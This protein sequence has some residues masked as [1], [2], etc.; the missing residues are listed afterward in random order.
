MGKLYDF[1]FSTIPLQNQKNASWF[2]TTKKDRKKI[3]ERLTQGMPLILADGLSD[4]VSEVLGNG[5]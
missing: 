1:M 3:Q 5:C 4:I 2:P